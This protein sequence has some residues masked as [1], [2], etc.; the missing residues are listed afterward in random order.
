MED[1]LVKEF[2]ESVKN[3]SWRFDSARLSDDSEKSEMDNCESLRPD[4]MIDKGCDR[5]MTMANSQCFLG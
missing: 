5:L 1:V 4:E 2:E 3:R